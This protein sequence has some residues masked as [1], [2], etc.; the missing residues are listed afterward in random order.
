MVQRAG[1]K[2]GLI[3]IDLM[4]DDDE[5]DYTFN[6]DETDPEV[7]QRREPHAIPAPMLEIIPVEKT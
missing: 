6:H 7:P 3:I 4:G 5:I 1:T 2:R